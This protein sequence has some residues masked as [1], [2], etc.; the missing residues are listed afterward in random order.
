M[1]LLI[2]RLT[3]NKSFTLT[4]LVSTALTG[5]WGIVALF[6]VAFQ[7]RLPTPWNTTTQDACPN[8]VRD[9]A[10]TLLLLVNANTLPVR[11]MGR[12]RSLQPGH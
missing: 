8:L 2:A 12:H 9:T 7:C 11:Q 1:F 6:V 4:C 3:R 10:S 5:M